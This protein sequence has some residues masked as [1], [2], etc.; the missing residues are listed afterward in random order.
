MFGVPVSPGTLGRGR[1]IGKRA[2]G[3]FACAGERERTTQNP[4]RLHRLSARRPH[5][6]DRAREFA[7]QRQRDDRPELG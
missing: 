3:D 5:A 4:N 2:H 7:R 1:A 6:A